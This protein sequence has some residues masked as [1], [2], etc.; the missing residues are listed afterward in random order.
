[1]EGYGTGASRISIARTAQ[2]DNASASATLQHRTCEQDV[3]IRR[4][5]DTAA[6]PLHEV[7]ALPL[8]ERTT[9]GF[10][11]LHPRSS[12]FGKAEDHRR[13][14]GMCRVAA[15]STKTVPRAENVGEC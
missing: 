2:Y 14:V 12:K 4:P 9:D 5:H 3:R 10:P 1:M 8:G 6:T 11:R 13:L 7:P 15:S